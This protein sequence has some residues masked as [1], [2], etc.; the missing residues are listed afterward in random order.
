MALVTGNTDQIALALCELLELKHVRSIT[1]RAALD[2]VSTVTVEYFPES[3]G[4]PV[5]LPVT[6]RFR[7]VEID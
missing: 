3:N 2:E 4:K 7:L 6:K 5:A 1:Y